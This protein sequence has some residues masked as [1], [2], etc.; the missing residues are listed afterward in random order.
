MKVRIEVEKLAE[1]ENIVKD[2]VTVS[3]RKEGQDRIF[4]MLPAANEE[5]QTVA[6]GLAYSIADKM[7]W[8]VE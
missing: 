2:M 1:V 8:E 5:S 7:G 6:R 4:L 3:F